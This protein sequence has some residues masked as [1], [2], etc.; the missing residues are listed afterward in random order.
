MLQNKRIVE[1]SFVGGEQ[2]QDF[3]VGSRYFFVVHIACSQP[4]N[5]CKFYQLECSSDIFVRIVCISAYTWR[6]QI[7]L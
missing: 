6:L 7:R 1:V 2:V 5:F 3:F 4:K